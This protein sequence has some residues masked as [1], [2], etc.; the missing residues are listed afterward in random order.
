M[1]LYSP[2]NRILLKNCIIVKLKHLN[3]KLNQ[4]ENDSASSEKISNMEDMISYYANLYEILKVNDTQRLLA[5]IHD[6]IQEEN[7]ADFNESVIKNS[8]SDIAQ[9]YID[10]TKSLMEENDVYSTEKFEEL[11]R[12][13][14]KGNEHLL[15]TVDYETLEEEPV[16]EQSQTT[17]YLTNEMKTSLHNLQELLEQ[18]KNSNTM[19]PFGFKN[20]SLQLREF[21]KDLAK[22]KLEQA[23]EKKIQEDSLEIEY[24]N[25]TARPTY[26]IHLSLAESPTQVENL[27]VPASTSGF[28]STSFQNLCYTYLE[29]KKYST[30]NETLLD[31]SIIATKMSAFRD[32]CNLLTETMSKFCFSISNGHIFQKGYSNFTPEEKDIA[33]DSPTS[34]DE[35]EIDI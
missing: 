19:T 21:V 14:Y 12:A 20:F 4:L 6:T 27:T 17:N 11:E 18:N 15:K 32:S 2:Q 22:Y 23:Y 25:K 13:F 28:I 8:P 29:A 34:N 1:D 3:I 26:R 24:D 7:L 31:S 9:E 5:T 30:T 33:C 16:L 10:L 35:N